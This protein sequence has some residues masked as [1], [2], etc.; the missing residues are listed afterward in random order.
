MVDWLHWHTE[1]FLTGGLLFLAWLY[2]ALTWPLRDLLAPGRSFERGKAW[3]FYSS[4]G[5]FY[6]AVGSPLDQLGEQFL[7]SAH[8]V[9]HQ[10]LIYPSAILFLRGIPDWFCPAT[11]ERGIARQ[12]LRLIL[13]PAFCGLSYILVL[14]AWH[15]PALYERA[16]E[17]RVIHVLEHFSF[18]GAALLFWWPFFSPFRSFPTAGH[19][20]RMLYLVLVTIGMTPLFFYITF[21][22]SPLYPAYEYAPRLLASLR[23]IDDQV[24]AGALMKLVGMFVSLGFFL[25]SF[26]A[27][28]RSDAQASRES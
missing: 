22:A 21:A 18:F 28:Y 15:V 8:M 19:G 12:V 13:S 10:I 27:W 25:S 4:L 23:P 20:L 3:C 5:L 16:L 14:S 24:L 17:N 2:A 1:P 6:I 26:M 7:L 9:Q 11:F